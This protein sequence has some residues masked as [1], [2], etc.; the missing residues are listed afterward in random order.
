MP[1]VGGEYKPGDIVDIYT[2]AA[3]QQAITAAKAGPEPQY[4]TATNIDYSELDESPSAGEVN[5]LVHNDWPTTNLLRW[6]GNLTMEDDPNFVQPWDDLDPKYYQYKDLFKNADSS[7]QWYTAIG[8]ADQEIYDREMM[9]RMTGKDWAQ[10]VGGQVIDP[11]TVALTLGTAP[12]YS[13]GK[14]LTV[15]AATARTAALAA[16]ESAVIEGILQLTDPTR[17][18]SDSAISVLAGGA[19]GALL[20]SG[21]QA[22]AKRFE[23]NAELKSE[24]FHV[25]KDEVDVQRA[26]NAI[27]DGE[28]PKYTAKDE[29]PTRNPLRYLLDNPIMRNAQIRLQYSDSP[30][31]S[32]L[33]DKLGASNILKHGDYNG[34]RYNGPTLN[35]TIKKTQRRGFK[36]LSDLAYD[37]R[38]TLKKKG[39]HLSIDEITFRATK[40][41]RRGGSGDEYDEI[42]RIGAQF[43]DD[44]KDWAERGVKMKVL[45]KEVVDAMDNYVPRIYDK[46][47]ILKDW[48]GWSSK[49]TSHFRAKYPD[50]DE[51][52]LATIP[53]DIYNKITSL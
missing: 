27:P 17:E 36:V 25:F 32:R 20:G 5:S 33:G 10:Y 23:R 4:M 19:F 50:M 52:T 16:G 14:G 8:V 38:R 37:A 26:N 53:R 39:V 46:Q 13:L 2:I 47:A 35:E 34:T 43:R 15:G 51:A 31:L 41:A 30:I 29:Q 7:E 22:L 40:S 44:M 28:T 11:V 9:E 45:S 6:I 18:M 1:L 21:G 48:D 3:Q 42:N 49:I 12:L 24:I